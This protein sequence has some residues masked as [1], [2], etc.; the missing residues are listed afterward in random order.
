M[1]GIGRFIVIEG[2]E[3]AGKS[4]AIATL[5]TVLTEQGIPYCLTREPGGTPIGEQLRQILKN[6]VYKE[7]LDPRS[8]LLMMY[9]ARIQ[10][11]EELIK[12]AL[13]A[14]TWVISDRFELSSLAY[15]GGG[16]QLDAGFIQALS[17]FALAGFKPDLTLYLQVDPDTGMQR[18]D[19]RGARDRI[20]QEQMSFFH[21]VAAVYEQAL[22][23]DSSLFPIDAMQA[24]ADV[25]AQIR[26]VL[27]SFLLHLGKEDGR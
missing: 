3:G 11:V 22:Q 15:Q 9:T 18:A 8:E 10:L 26:Q 7:S 24:F 14:G 6:P 17:G 25:Q 1:P 5:S 21:R 16:R 23:S 19:T 4:S 2:L 13:A 12:P 20:E 27:T